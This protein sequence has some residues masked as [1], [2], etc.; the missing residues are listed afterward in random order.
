VR[1]QIKI[2][3][4]LFGV[5]ITTLLGGCAGDAQLRADVAGANI[6]IARQQAQAAAQP[7]VRMSCPVAGCVIYSLEV[8][9]PMAGQQPP[10][11][12]LDDPWAR[13][14]DRAMG[15]LGTAAGIY[16]GGEAAANIA[17]TVASGISG[18]LGASY[19]GSNAGLGAMA[20]Y[21]SDALT[22]QAGAVAGALDAMPGPVVFNQPPPVVVTQPPPVLVPS[23]P[24][25]IVRPEVVQPVIVPGGGL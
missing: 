3:V 1:T 18:A 4:V 23:A 11:A 14:A 8:S 13:V 22:T 9:N 17:G 5:S 25:V 16:L 10:V 24:P 20:G 12:M 15:V 2:L 21:G 6:E 7:L 19:A